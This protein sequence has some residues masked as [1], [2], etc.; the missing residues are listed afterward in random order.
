MIILNVVISLLGIGLVAA[1]MRFGY[2]L[3]GGAFERR[4]C[5][6][7]L[8]TTSRDLERAA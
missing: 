1:I 5:V 8:R 4:V 6:A 3:G 2:L 7:E